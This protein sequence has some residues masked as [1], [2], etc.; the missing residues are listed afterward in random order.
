MANNFHVSYSNVPSYTHCR[1]GIVKSRTVGRVKR[2]SHW[3]NGGQF[4][5]FSVSEIIIIIIIIN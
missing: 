3:F 5:D 2:E 4:G 1:S